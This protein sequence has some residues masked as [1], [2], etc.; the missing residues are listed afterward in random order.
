MTLVSLLEAPWASSLS[1][2][3]VSIQWEAAGLHLEG[4]SVTRASRVLPPRSA[5][6]SL[7][8]CEKKSAAVY[9]PLRPRHFIIVAWMD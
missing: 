9:K 2:H 1:F 8:N 6:S 7:Q 4:G 3:Q 5:A